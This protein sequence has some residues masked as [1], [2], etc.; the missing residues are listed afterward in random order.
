MLTRIWASKVSPSNSRNILL[1]I[2]TFVQ[3]GFFRALVR[4]TVG[5]DAA[6]REFR[7]HRAI[8]CHY[9]T[10]FQRKLNGSQSKIYLNA[11]KPEMFHT[12]AYWICTV[13]LWLPETSTDG[14]IPMEWEH[15]L[16]RFSFAARMDI[17]GLHN[18][19]MTV[20]F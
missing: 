5:K 18:A 15:L 11:E 17:Q 20:I 13:R 6:K 4:I 3:G 12:C 9:S 16:E 19:T 7:V 1:L 8:L 2:F 14:K 10:H